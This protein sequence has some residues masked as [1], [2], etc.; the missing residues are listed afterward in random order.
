[1]D[2]NLNNPLNQSTTP[3]NNDASTPIADN[4][5]KANATSAKKK[6]AGLIVALSLVAAFFGVF[7]ISTAVTNF[8]SVKIPLLSKIVPHFNFNK[9]T[10]KAIENEAKSGKK[11]YPRQYRHGKNI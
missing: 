4:L 9:K 10:E 6:N 1:M 2:N 11:K 5:Q 8:T 3:V 7:V